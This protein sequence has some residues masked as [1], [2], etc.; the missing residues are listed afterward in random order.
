M[1]NSTT[2]GIDESKTTLSVDP[3]TNIY[4]TAKNG[5]WIKDLTQ[6]RRGVGLVKSINTQ[7]KGMQVWWPKSGKTSWMVVENYGHYKVI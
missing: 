4:P 2:L 6:S 3:F 7:T 5:N 1:S